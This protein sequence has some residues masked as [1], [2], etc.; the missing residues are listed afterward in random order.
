MST[1]TSTLEGSNCW[2]QLRQGVLRLIKLKMNTSY[3]IQARKYW[4]EAG[5][6][7]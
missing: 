6:Y 1:L 2:A 7:P 4:V 3:Q 5:L